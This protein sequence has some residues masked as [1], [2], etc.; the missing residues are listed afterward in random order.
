MQST[1]PARG[2][3]VSQ[4][5][6]V[7]TIVQPK[8]SIDGWMDFIAAHSALVIHDQGFGFVD[9]GGKAYALSLIVTL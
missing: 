7:W 1:G 8:A 4:F 6:G 2:W 3:F 5:I 9:Y